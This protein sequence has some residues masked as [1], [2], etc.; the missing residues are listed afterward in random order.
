MLNHLLRILMVVL[1]VIKIGFAY[2]GPLLGRN[3]RNDFN[4][5]RRFESVFY[6]LVEFECGKKLSGQ[7]GHSRFSGSPYRVCSYSTTI[8]GFKTDRRF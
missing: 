8:S 3:G 4:T 1:V 5:D 2:I 7:K 6:R